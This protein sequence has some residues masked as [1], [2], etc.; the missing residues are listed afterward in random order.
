M[1]SKNWAEGTDRLFLMENHSAMVEGATK[2]CQVWKLSF[3]QH[4]VRI[5]GSDFGLWAENLW[6]VHYFINK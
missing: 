2:A 5:Q 3:V 1:Y 4:A 6:E